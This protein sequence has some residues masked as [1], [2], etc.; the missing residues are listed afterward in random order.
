MYIG[1]V[2][3][4]YVVIHADV[5]DQSISPFIAMCISRKKYVYVSS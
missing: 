4:Y 1:I 5:L 2:H 3:I